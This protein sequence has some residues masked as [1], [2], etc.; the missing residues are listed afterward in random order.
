MSGQSPCLDMA[1]DTR[2]DCK[3]CRGLRS[4][5]QPTLVRFRMRSLLLKRSSL[6]LS[7]PPNLSR[8][9]S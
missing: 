3:S 2:V 8:L 1:T 7:C 9:H 4:S 5:Q 6:F